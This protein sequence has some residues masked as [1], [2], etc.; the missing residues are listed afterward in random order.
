MQPVTVPVTVPVTLIK[1]YSVPRY[2]NLLV[3]TVDLKKKIAEAT[4][5]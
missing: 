2:L 3:G 4:E 1:T 5:K